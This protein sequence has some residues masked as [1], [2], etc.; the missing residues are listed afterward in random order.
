ML[1]LLVHR[2]PRERL[3][4]VSEHLLVASQFLDVVFLLLQLLLQSHAPCTGLALVKARLDHSDVRLRLIHKI[5]F[6]SLNLIIILHFFNRIQRTHCQRLHLLRPVLPPVLYPCLQSVALVLQ[7]LLNILVR[8][9]H[10]LLVVPDQVVVLY[11]LFLLLHFVDLNHQTHFFLSA[12]LQRRNRYLPLL[13]RTHLFLSGS[14]GFGDE[15]VLRL[16]IRLP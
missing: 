13:H 16:S 9:R 3:E 11:R 15:D 8:L 14:E 7:L 2:L 1:V 5:I 12:L 10:V 6:L 4:L